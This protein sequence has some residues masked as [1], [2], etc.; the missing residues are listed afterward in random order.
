MFLSGSRQASGVGSYEG[1]NEPWRATEAEN[2]WTSLA[3]ISV[4]RGLLPNGVAAAVVY[5]DKKDEEKDEEEE[6]KEK[7]NW[8]MKK[9]NRKKKKS[10]RMRKRKEQEQKEEEEKDKEEEQKD[11]GEEKDKEEEQKDEE[12]E[13]KDKEEEQKDEEE[14]KGEEEEMMKRRRYKLRL[15]VQHYSANLPRVLTLT[16]AFAYTMHLSLA[17]LLH[18][19]TIDHFP[20]QN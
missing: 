2:F 20:A 5:D 11:E 14:E 18:I 8:S 17:W 9:R 4:S 13:E 1:G 3:T 6:E 7:K 12:E 15:V 10:R 19:T 16:T